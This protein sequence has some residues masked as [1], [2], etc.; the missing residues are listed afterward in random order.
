MR[1]RPK[2]S[3]DTRVIRRFLLLS[4]SMYRRIKPPTKNDPVGR[5]SKEKETRW[6][7][8]ATWKQQWNAGRAGEYA[9]HWHDISWED[10]YKKETL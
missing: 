6:L 5:V 1:Y 8:V 10:G 2:H 9:S 7:E 3:G 4:R